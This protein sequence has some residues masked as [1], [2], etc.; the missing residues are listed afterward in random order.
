M[1]NREITLTN[2][3]LAAFLQ[4]GDCPVDYKCLA[5]D[6]M[7]CIEIYMTQEADHGTKAG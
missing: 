6:C 3:E 4:S 5:M 1:G 7:K 2:V